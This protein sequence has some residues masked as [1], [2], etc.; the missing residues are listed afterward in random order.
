[1]SDA[2]LENPNGREDIFSTFDLNLQDCTQ[3]ISIPPLDM[4][5][6]LCLKMTIF[7]KQ[8]DVIYNCVK[9]STLPSNERCRN[10][11]GRFFFLFIV[12]VR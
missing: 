2:R 4:P 10:R 7:M 11:N 6:F 3:H 1:M 9:K 12:N 5:M 8:I